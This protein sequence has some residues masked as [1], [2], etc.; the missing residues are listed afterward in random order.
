MTEL[1]SVNDLT[2][3]LAAQPKSHQV[4][5]EAEGDAVGLGYHL[6][7][8][9][10]ARI[11]S[12]DCGGVEDAWNEAQMQ[13]LDA[14]GDAAMSAGKMAAIL[15][16]SAAAIDDLAESPLNVEFS[17]GNQGVGRYQFGAPRLSDGVITLPLTKMQPECKA[18]TRAFRKPEATGCCDQREVTAACC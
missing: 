14:P 15:A 3:F 8:L 12:I 18:M 10:L 6:T 9:R 11:S 1:T 2:T 7:E 16:R 5:F 17:H 13:V 4:L